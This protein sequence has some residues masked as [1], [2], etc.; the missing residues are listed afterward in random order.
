MQ[1][2]YPDLDDVQQIEEPAI[3]IPVSVQV[4]GPVVVHQLPSRT[5]PVTTEILSTTPVKVLSADPKRRRAVICGTGD[6]YVSHI[7]SASGGG[8]WPEVV[9]L[10][11]EHGDA[12]YAYV[13]GM[14]A[15]TLTI[16]TE[17]W[18]D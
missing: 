7:N 18:A 17:Y 15:S 5:G 14:G 1:D 8:V 12:V 13:V 4:D 2:A 11:I 3:A 16:V 6:W 9:P 10:V